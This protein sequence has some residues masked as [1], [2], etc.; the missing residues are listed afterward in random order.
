MSPQKTASGDA[1]RPS[2]NRRQQLAAES[3][4]AER[5]RR[6]RRRLGFGLLAASLAVILF[7]G[8]WLG[9]SAFQSRS[10]QPT[11]SEGSWTVGVGS[12]GAPVRV[13]VYQDFM[14]PYC[15]QFEQVNGPVLAR[16]V[17]QGMVRLEIHPIS[18]LDQLSEGTEYSTRS[19]N[20]FVTAAQ[21]DPGTVLDFNSAL[22]ANQPAEGSPGLTDEQ[23][24]DVALSA[25][26]DPTV[27]DTFTE[28]AYEDWVE[29]GTEQAFAD[30]VTGTPTILVDGEQFSGDILT[31]GPLEAAIRAAEGA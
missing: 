6:I 15:G 23:L 8:I 19:A 28:M 5:D 11:A 13:D 31:A 16:L 9:V 18:F 3:A 29:D 27:V 20:A 30:G 4:R 22:F 24:A 1:S 17:D 7:A 26:I 10:S 2:G 21:A 25:G 14:C 12:A